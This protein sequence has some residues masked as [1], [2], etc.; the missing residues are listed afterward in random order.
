MADVLS[1]LSI[2]VG[3]F[4]GKLRPL[5]YEKT[6]YRASRPPS[7]SASFPIC[8]HFTIRLRAA[9]AGLRARREAS[10]DI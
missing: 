9:A 7:L 4:V 3:N 5:E 2:Q 8:S 10:L 1:I 6:G